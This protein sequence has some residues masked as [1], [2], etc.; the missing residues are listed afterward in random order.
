M[1]DIEKD[2]KNGIARTHQNA[3]MVVQDA[4]EDLE[5]SDIWRIFNPDSKRF[6][7]RQRQAE[8]QRRL[9]F[10]LVS[11]T[12]L[13]NCSD[14]DIIPGFKTDHSM[15]TLNLSL[16]SN[17]RGNGFWNLNTSLLTDT[18]CGENKRNYTRNGY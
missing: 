15:I 5:L 12:R 9:D 14:T 18:I 17:P 2:K 1:L 13:Y 6:T 4:M 7:W 10:F 16:H 11:Q 3:L 8:I